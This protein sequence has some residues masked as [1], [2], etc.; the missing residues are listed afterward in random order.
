MGMIWSTK[1]TSKTTCVKGLGYWRTTQLSIH[2]NTRDSGKMTRRMDTESGKTK[3]GKGG[4]QISN[5]CRCLRVFPLYW[6]GESLMFWQGELGRS[7]VFSLC[8]KAWTPGELQSWVCAVSLAFMLCGALYQ[9]NVASVGD[10]SDW[11]KCSEIEEKKNV[12]YCIL[13]GRDT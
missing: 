13:E 1:A 6:H 9:V 5:G 2:L 12:F 4:V 3:T 7:N 11:L 10:I 8:Y